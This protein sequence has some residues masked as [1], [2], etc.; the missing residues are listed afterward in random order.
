[1]SKQ[2]QGSMALVGAISGGILI[3][4]FVAL[5]VVGGW[6]FSPAAFVA[7]LVAGGAAVVLLRGFHRKPASPVATQATQR[8]APA[9]ASAPSAAPASVTEAA[10]QPHRSPNRRPNRHMSRR[11]SLRP[12][13]PRPRRGAAGP[14]DLKQLSGVGPALEKKLH[15]VGVTTFAQIAAW[16]AR[17]SPRWTRSSPSRAGS[18]VTAGSNRPSG[19]PR[20]DRLGTRSRPRTKEVC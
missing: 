6:D 8:A 12:Q 17:I 9:A 10:P 2:T 14:D 13:R 18:N 19:L 4:A 5:M 20:A 11:P 16:S 7:L 15:E 1:M 3:V